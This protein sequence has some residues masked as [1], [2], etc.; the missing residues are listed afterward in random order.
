MGD[1]IRKMFDE[2]TVHNLGK[3]KFKKNILKS[4]ERKYKIYESL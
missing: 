1:S 2:W 4:L 3:W